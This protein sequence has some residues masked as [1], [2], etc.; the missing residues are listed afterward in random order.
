MR[1]FWY[2]GECCTDYGI[3]VSGESTFG[4]PKRDI[5]EIDVPGRNG[6]LTID[7][8]RFKN[9]TV[10]YPALVLPNFAQNSAAA[11]AWLL[12]D[13][14]YRKL[15]DEYHPDS[16]RMARF[17]GPVDFDTHFLNK[18]GEVDL[19][20]DCKPQRYL[21][22]GENV[23]TVSASGTVLRSQTLFA[24]LPLIKVYGSGSGAMQ[25]G[26][27]SVSFSAI[28]EYVYLDC[29]TQNAYKGTE[30]KNSTITA[31]EFPALFS[32]DNVIT[33][34]GGVTGMEITPRWWTV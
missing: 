27:V 33:W 4:A 16:Y 22:T 12:Q 2:G 14:G 13:A 1:R 34:S 20:F 5:T 15:E 32:G 23:L 19:A 6:T 28:D 9:I 31:P 30:N 26:S 24:A 21:R 11:V 7:N 17:S 18:S 3:A 29:D 10:T 8:N 25:I